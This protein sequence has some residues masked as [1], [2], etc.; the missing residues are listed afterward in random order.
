MD[1]AGG[2]L[3]GDGF[4][5]CE[6]IVRQFVFENFASKYILIY[7]LEYASNES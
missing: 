7:L 4:D 5:P 3:G 2:N 6:C 1:G